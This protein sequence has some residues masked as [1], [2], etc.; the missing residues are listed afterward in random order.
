MAIDYAAA[1]ADAE[2]RVNAWLAILEVQGR[3]APHGRIARAVRA[4]ARMAAPAVAFARAA[5]AEVTRTYDAA[6]L[7]CWQSRRHHDAAVRTRRIAYDAAAHAWRCVGCYRHATRRA[8]IVD[9]I[10]RVDAAIAA[11]RDAA[12]WRRRATAAVLAYRAACDESAH[13]RTEASAILFGGWAVDA[14]ATHAAADAAA[15]VRISTDALVGMIYAAAADAIRG[16][17]PRR[18]APSA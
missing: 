4:R 3:L 15:D 6:A 1:R 9:A 17:R 18:A 11:R 14:D 2:T 8:A 5:A 16:M 13:W 10:A 12:E 7:A